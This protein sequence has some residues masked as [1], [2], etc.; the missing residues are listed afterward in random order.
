MGA[1]IFR[2]KEDPGIPGQRL[3]DDDV[4]V[5]TIREIE[6]KFRQFYSVA[7]YARGEQRKEV[8]NI[9]NDTWK[10]VKYF[11][12]EDDTSAGLLFKVAD[13]SWMMVELSSRGF[14]WL[15]RKKEDSKRVNDLLDRIKVTETFREKVD[16]NIVMRLFM[17]Q[18][19]R[20]YQKGI[21]F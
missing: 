3:L 19:D 8:Y 18:K 17:A 20:L 21:K 5:D 1:A 16:V 14:F 11:S 7:L 4:F 12:K 13:G 6:L 15:Y 9:T 10:T 2:P